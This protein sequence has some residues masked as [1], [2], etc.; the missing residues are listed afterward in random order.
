MRSEGKREEELRG[1]GFVSTRDPNPRFTLKAL[2]VHQPV[3]SNLQ[4]LAH[5][6]TLHFYTERFRL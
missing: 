2:S 6:K 5:S 1:R 4:A 3:H